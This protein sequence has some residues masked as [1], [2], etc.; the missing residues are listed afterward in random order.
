MVE[1]PPLPREKV[2]IGPAGWHYS[3]WAGIVYPSR[4]P[5]GF[6]ELGY[7]AEF[8]DTVEINT[9]FYQPPKPQIVKVWLHR[10]AHNPYFRFTAKL[11]QRF[12]HQCYANRAD[13]IA[14]KEG[15]DPL[16]QAGKLGAL[17]L[18]FPWSFRNTKQNREYLGGLVM[19]FMEYPLVVE[20]R[21]GSWNHPD[22]YRMLENLEVGFCNIDQPQIGSSLPP[23]ERNTT[24]LGY[25]RLHGRNYE[26]WIKPGEFPEQRYNY[27]YSLPELHPWE[28]KIRHIADQTQITYV[29]ANNHFRGKSITNALQLVSLL[30]GRRV[31]APEGLLQWYPEL[32]GMIR[33]EPGGIFQQTELPFEPFHSAA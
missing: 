1:F 6:H 3:D 26:K 33:I 25:V 8:F 2:K 13:E 27:L 22:I 21:H 18:Q 4:R 12:T 30:R 14:F 16:M 32:E 15:L 20:V 7:L 11:W 24:S 9:T 29:I 23:T 19:Q 28:E 31:P 5:R 17:L 10:V